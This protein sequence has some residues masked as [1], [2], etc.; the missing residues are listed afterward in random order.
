M[1]IPSTNNST[2]WLSKMT[3]PSTLLQT[4]NIYD[5]FLPIPVDSHAMCNINNKI[6]RYGGSYTD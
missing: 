2:E 6:Y 1:E 4:L 5:Q 3:S